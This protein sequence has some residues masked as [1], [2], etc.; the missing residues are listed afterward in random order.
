MKIES[1]QK[2]AADLIA[3]AEA[4]SAFDDHGLKQLQDEFRH[5]SDGISRWAEERIAEAK[6]DGR[7]VLHA[8]DA[9]KQ[10]SF[11][12]CLGDVKGAMAAAIATNA[13]CRSN[14]RRVQGSGEPAKALPIL[15]SMREYREHESKAMGIG[16][17]TT[18]GYTTFTELGPFVRYLEAKSIIF[19]ANPRVF[20]MKQDKLDLPKLT[21]SSTVYHAGEAGSVTASDL[22]LGRVSL[23]SKAYAVRV[24][25]S[26]EWFDDSNPEARQLLSDDMRNRLALKYDI[27]ALEGEGTSTE[28]IVGIR[29]LSGVTQTEVAAGAGNGAAVALADFVNAIDRIRRDNGTPTFVAMHPRTWGSVQKLLDG[30]NRPML[31]PDPTQDASMRLFGLPVLL[32][33]QISIT[34][35]QGSSS[36]CSYAIVG[37]GQQLAVGIRTENV[38][39]YNPFSY[40]STRQI[41]VVSHSRLAFNVLNTEALEIIEG[42]RAI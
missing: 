18:G 5:F 14:K 36:D 41:E 32:S 19:Q 12:A 21:G 39:I 33:S 24:I 29:N 25:G 27:D 11:R 31:Q 1:V 35:T 4:L 8:D 2:Q 17:D 22:T 30:Q 10:L 9:R 26:Q 20:P 34:E 42:I 28:P 6:A 37:D 23:H 40:A 13:E 16:S 15:P 7:D 38:T 3:S